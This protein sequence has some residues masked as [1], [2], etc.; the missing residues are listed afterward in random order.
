[1]WIFSDVRAGT[2]L[3]Q[4]DTILA[5]KRLETRALSMLENTEIVLRQ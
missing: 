3:P 4:P 2:D 1:L 5:T